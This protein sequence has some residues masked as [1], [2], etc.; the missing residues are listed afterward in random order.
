MS[1]FADLVARLVAQG[2]FTTALDVVEGPRARVPDGN[3]P[4]GQITEYGGT[5]TLE[6]HNSRYH[7]PSAQIVIIA[8]DGSVAKTKAFA[9]RDALHFY[10]TTVNGTWYLQSVPSQEPYSFPP[11]A[12]ERAR[13]GFNVDVIKAP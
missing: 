11:D 5:A 10:N 9:A 1:V 13:F 2:V 4:Y 7:R 8:Q 6:A 3:G 12:K